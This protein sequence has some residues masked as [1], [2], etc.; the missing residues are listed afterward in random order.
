MDPHGRM[1]FGLPLSVRGADA[2]I[3]LE[4]AAVLSRACGA[5]ALA[6]PLPVPIDDWIE[7]PLGYDFSIVGDGVLPDGAVGLARP[8]LNEIVVHESALAHEGRYRFTCAHELGHCVLHQHVS[9]ELS[10]GELPRD[11]TKSTIEREAD[12]FAAALLMPLDTIASQL[13]RSMSAHALGEHSIEVLRGDDVRAVWAWRRCLVPMLA[14]AYQVSR[15]AMV[16]RLRELRLP[17]A[18]RLVRPSLVPLL[19]AP[20]RILRH[21]P[22]DHVR[23]EAGVPVVDL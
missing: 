23:V 18:R 22:L 10:D 19:A 9:K 16:Y 21:V 2:R 5:L 8:S 6:A 1:P 14:E 7:T 4:A 12:R 17:G 13:S 11:S 15:A 20:E 3:E